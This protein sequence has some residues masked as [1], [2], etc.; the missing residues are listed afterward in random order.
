MAT[1]EED[2]EYP[3]IEPVDVPIVVDHP[4]NGLMTI[5][6][7][8]P[9][10]LNFSEYQRSALR[11]DSEDV[12][13]LSVHVFLLRIAARLHPVSDDMDLF[14]VERTF[15]GFKVLRVTSS[16]VEPKKPWILSVHP[17]YFVCDRKSHGGASSTNRSMAVPWEATEEDNLA[18][19]KQAAEVFQQY[20]LDTMDPPTKAAGKE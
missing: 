5:D 11:G 19:V 2:P 16:T 6:P 18:R 1:P 9:K 14:T 7:S 4:V 17:N 3:G 13:D 8:Q 10:M 20:M 15:F 12:A